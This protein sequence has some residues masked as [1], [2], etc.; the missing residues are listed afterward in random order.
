MVWCGALCGC[1]PSKRN[2]G[3]CAAHHTPVPHMSPWGS[4]R[5]LRTIT[6]TTSGPPHPPARRT[7]VRPT[8][9]PCRPRGLPSASDEPRGEGVK[10]KPCAGLR[11]NGGRGAGRNTLHAS[12]HHTRVVWARRPD[13]TPWELPHAATFRPTM[14]AL[15]AVC[16]GRPHCPSDTPCDPCG[17][18][19]RSMVPRS[20]GPQLQRNHTSA[21]PRPMRIAC[22]KVRPI[23]RLVPAY[24]KC[25]RTASA[26][27][28][29]YNTRGCA[30]P[31]MHTQSPQCAPHRS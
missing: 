30:P 28:P 17:Y 22:G 21:Q 6:T 27:V 1:L 19:L 20:Q 29:F 14:C 18:S 24:V 26:T 23:A 8:R 16:C 12:P 31:P 7:H 4:A 25:P 5:R 3:H 11:A 9:C 13:A 10:G 2:G 15:A